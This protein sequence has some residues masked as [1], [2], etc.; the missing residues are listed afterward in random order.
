MIY[1]VDFLKHLP[2]PVWTYLK[3]PEDD[4]ENLSS[5]N[6]VSRKCQG[7]EGRALTGRHNC[8]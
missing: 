4:T 6:R 7:E 5:L 2:F 8:E 1:T 3:Y